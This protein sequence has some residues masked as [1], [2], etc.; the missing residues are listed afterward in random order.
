MILRFQQKLA[1]WV[2]KKESKLFQEYN[3]RR[4]LRPSSFPYVSGDSF[5]AL[6]THVYDESSTFNSEHVGPGSIVFVKTDML[7]RFE[8]EMLP[9]IHEQFVLITHNSDHP[10]DSRHS[11]L[12]EDFRIHR[13]F[14]QN[15]LLQHPKVIRIPIGL[16]NR[17]RHKNGIIG[18]FRKLADSCHLKKNRI[19][20]AFSVHTNEAERRPAVEALCRCPV[21][22]TAKGLNSREYRKFL[23]GYAFVASPP[24]NGIDCHRTWEAL[25]LDTV[26]IIKKSAFYGGFPNL[27]AIMVNDWSELELIDSRYLESCYQTLPHP[28][29]RTEYIWMSFWERMIEQ[30]KQESLQL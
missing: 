30:A 7:D 12:A 20:Y 9:G 4:K 15:A 17:W 1:N 2:F 25:Y 21:A 10:V 26:P 5:R 18:D 16:E 28:P 14:A 29:S 23:A 19:L 3:Q 22:D 8:R 24:G 6:A 11:R 13:W 27:P